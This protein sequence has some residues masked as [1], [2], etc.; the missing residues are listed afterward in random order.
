MMIRDD[1]LQH[2]ALINALQYVGNRKLENWLVHFAKKNMFVSV[3]QLPGAWFTR[4][5][6]GFANES[7]LINGRFKVSSAIAYFDNKKYSL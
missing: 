6:I 4:L 2:Q 1:L 5:D 7:E 3:M